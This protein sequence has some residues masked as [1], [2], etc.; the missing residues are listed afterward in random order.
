MIHVIF[1]LL[2]FLAG[3]SIIILRM[4]EIA[5]VNHPAAKIAF[6][7]IFSLVAPFSNSHLM[8]KSIPGQEN[9][10]AFDVFQLQQLEVREVQQIFQLQAIFRYLAVGL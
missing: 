3:D 8:I 10:S 1:F 4:Q 9:L 7:R 5:M 2:P 6:H